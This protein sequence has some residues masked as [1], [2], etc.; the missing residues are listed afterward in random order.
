MAKAMNYDDSRGE[1]VEQRYLQE[2]VIEYF[3]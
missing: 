2:T 1:Q 3:A